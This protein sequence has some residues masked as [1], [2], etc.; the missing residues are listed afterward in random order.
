[1]CKLMYV[2][3]TCALQTFN[4]KVYLCLIPTG[5]ELMLKNVTGY[6][7]EG[8]VLIKIDG[9]VGVILNHGIEDITTVQTICRLL[10]FG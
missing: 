3:L 5:A 10:G 8:P 9:T 1:M 2:Q 4:C 7:Y 6:D